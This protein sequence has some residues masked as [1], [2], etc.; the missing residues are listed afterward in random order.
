[1]GQKLPS[2]ASVEN[3]NKNNINTIAEVEKN[4]HIT[5]C[6][7][8]GMDS[9]MANVNRNI[10][11]ISSISP[12][13]QWLEV[14]SLGNGTHMH[15]TYSGVA[16]RAGEPFVSLVPP[17]VAM[18][19]E[20][21]NSFPLVR[22]QSS[23][24][25]GLRGVHVVPP[26]RSNR[27]TTLQMLTKYLEEL[28]ESDHSF[29]LFSK[30]EFFKTMAGTKKGWKKFPE[31]NLGTVLYQLNE[32]NFSKSRLAIIS[33][34]T[35][36]DTV[37]VYEG[38]NGLKLEY[39]HASTSACPDITLHFMNR[40]TEWKNET[41]LFRYA[42]GKF[43]IR[44]RGTAI[45]NLQTAEKISLSGLSALMYSK[46]LVSRENENKMGAL[47]TLRLDLLSF[48]EAEEG[49]SV[50]RLEWM[51][52]EPMASHSSVSSQKRYATA[53]SAS[54]VSLT[55][56]YKSSS[57]Y[58]E[59]ESYTTTG[60]EEENVTE[61]TIFNGPFYFSPGSCVVQAAEIRVKVLFAL[62]IVPPPA[63]WIYRRESVSSSHK[64]K[65]SHAYKQNKQEQQQETPLMEP[66]AEKYMYVLQPPMQEE[67]D[68]P[69]HI[70]ALLRNEEKEF[71]QR[72]PRCNID[73]F[74]S[75][76]SVSSVEKQENVI[77]KTTDLQWHGAGALK[78]S[79]VPSQGNDSALLAI[80]QDRSFRVRLRVQDSCA[81]NGKVI[82]TFTFIVEHARSMGSSD[83]FLHLF[84]RFAQ[85][86][87]PISVDFS[88]NVRGDKM[89]TG[90]QEEVIIR[91]KHQSSSILATNVNDTS[92][93]ETTFM[94]G[95]NGIQGSIHLPAASRTVETSTS[96][97]NNQ[98]S[99][100]FR[101]TLPES[102]E[103]TLC[104]ADE[105]L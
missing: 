36:V 97:G 18:M 80:A 64:I 11:N 8:R 7:P 50:D 57:S 6:F 101:V 26:H 76:P 105:E 54:D 23:L 29:F 27:N 55:R 24:Q 14:S 48:N 19:D 34:N 67:L 59:R 40:N 39:I 72:V 90:K 33:S 32:E 74:T 89:E 79:L 63:L 86:K 13:Q 25:N 92:I 85:K 73:F 81:L 98:F 46:Q 69:V 99:F 16:K 83:V 37:G 78:K 10:T 52:A 61:R 56:P 82:R 71:K 88:E 77:E 94:R 28:D 12:T 95:T 96:K 9:D 66:S 60:T 84:H 49:M 93:L 30:K 31:T 5:S 45:I 15:I 104:D 58:S 70:H 103:K 38:V 91:L 51:E 43:S 4:E 75:S 20:T 100:F 41:L 47:A 17:N 1:V 21:G 62:C 42:I 35:S 2:F 53:A 68:V 102:M 87:F 22:L 44:V 3:S 65:K